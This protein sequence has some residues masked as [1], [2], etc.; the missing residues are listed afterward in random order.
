MNAKVVIV[1]RPNVGKS[2]LF[3][4]LAGR[5]LA[6]VHDRPGV[7]RDRR[8]GEAR[9]NGRAFTLIDT[10]G[11]DDAPRGSLEDRMSAQSEAAIRDADICLFMIDARAG[12]IPADR[13][14]ARLVRGLDKP[15]ILVAN[16]CE[17]RDVPPGVH[18]SHALGLG[19]P[20]CVSA[21]HA[22]G[23][24]A[25]HDVLAGHL[26][27]FHEARCATP[28]PPAPGGDEDT[29]PGPDRPLRLA[30]VG[31][32]NT[33]KSTLI[34]RLLGHERLLSG[35]EAG[36]T[37]DAIAV[38]WQV[39]D[40]PVK[41]FDTAGMRKKARVSEVLEKLSIGDTLRAIRFA[42]IVVLMIDATQP[43][44]KQDLQ[45]ADLIEREG[46]ALLIALNKWDLVKDKAAVRRRLGRAAERLLPQLRGVPLVT[47]SAATGRGLDRLMP[48]AFKLYER[49]NARAATAPLNRW[50]RDAVERH[51]PPA[52]AGRRLK[53]RYIT[54]AKARPPTFVLFCSRP[55]ALPAS[56]QRYLLNGLREAFHMPGTPLRLQ[57]RQGENPYVK[58]RSR[59]P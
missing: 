3:N 42:E 45:I 52:P 38:D 11:L 21:E 31:R 20:V 39:G 44:E 10:A 56:Y 55:D 25:L 29:V 2:T 54:Q 19:D 1:G 15:V 30:V 47:L 49:W 40:V 23:I 14:F 16:K 53:L 33:G 9:V 36:L 5:R 27:A 12:V 17:G 57:V 41:L 6:I 46:R 22:E 13:H 26:K 4:R 43:F 8:E 58:K 37:R 48:R 35:P 7:T 34:N 51:P 50:L 18:E 24:G 32:P 59:H 28:G